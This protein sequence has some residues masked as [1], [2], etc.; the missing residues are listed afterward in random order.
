MPLCTVAGTFRFLPFDD[1]KAQFFHG[2]LIELFLEVIPF[3]IIIILYC[4]ERGGFFLIGLVALIQTILSLLITIKH[5]HSAQNDENRSCRLTDPRT[6]FRLRE[7]TQWMNCRCLR[8]IPDEDDDTVD[9]ERRGEPGKGKPFSKT[10][11]L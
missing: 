2:V 3:A 6:C 5:V 7:R 9:T 10:F 4:S 1:F 8:Y 11:N